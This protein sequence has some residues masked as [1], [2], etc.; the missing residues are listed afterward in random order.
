MS[1]NDNETLGVYSFV[2]VGGTKLVLHILKHL[3]N[4]LQEIIMNM[5]HQMVHIL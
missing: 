1:Y 2:D 4:Q 3:V 5:V